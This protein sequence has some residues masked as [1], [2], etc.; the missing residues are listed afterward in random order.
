[1]NEHDTPIR[2]RRLLDAGPHL[3]G[4]G[5]SPVS[6]HIHPGSARHFL[7]W[8]IQSGIALDEVGRD[9]VARFAGHDCRCHS[10]PRLVG[11]YYINR[12]DRFVRHLAERGVLPPRPV[13]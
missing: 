13:A 10:A 6:V 2:R 8:L 4:T 7:A 12:V 11:Q 3:A 5:L 1:M 9:T